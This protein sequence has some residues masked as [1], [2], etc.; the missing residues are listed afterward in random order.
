[1]YNLGVSL[2]SKPMLAQFVKLIK[3]AK[4]VQLSHLAQFV[5]LIKFAKLV[6]LS[7]LAQFGK[8]FQATTCVCS[9]FTVMR[10]KTTRSNLKHYYVEL[11]DFEEYFLN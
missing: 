10:Y 6:Q 4:L 2:N 11:L 3:F 7:H 9:N 1:M 8:F 5:K